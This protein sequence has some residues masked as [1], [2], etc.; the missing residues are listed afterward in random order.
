MICRGLTRIKLIGHNQAQGLKIT[1][2]LQKITRMT[3]IALVLGSVVSVGVPAS[4]VEASCTSNPPTTY[5]TDTVTYNVPTAGTYRVW[6]RIWAPDAT[7]NSFYLSLDGACATVVGDNA[8][9]TPG[10]WVWV[11][12]QDA[13]TTSKI[14]M[15][16]TAGNHVFVLTGREPDVMVDRI[17]FASDTSCVPTGTGDNCAIAST[18]TPTPTATATPTAT[19]N[20]AD[21]NADGKVNVFDLSILLS[22]WNA[23]GSGDINA[24]GI[25]NVFDLSRLLNAWTG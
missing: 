17:V 2:M 24:D 6:S 18:P 14:N 11:D 23:S 7:N 21:L 10:Q 3:I 22:H 9:I 20:S 13:T 16:L 15:T 4:K 25:V 1:D 5:G 12:Y 19:P 8:A